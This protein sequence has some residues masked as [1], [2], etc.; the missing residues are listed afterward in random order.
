MSKSDGFGKGFASDIG[1]YGAGNMKHHRHMGNFIRAMRLDR[2]W[3]MQTLADMCVPPTTSSQI[4]K[5]E[6]GQVQ[7]TERWMRI[8][9]QALDC[10]AFDLIDGGPE[11]LAPR[12]QSLVDLFR[13]L[14]EA[15]RD[16]FY[17]TAA[18]LAEP[19][20]DTDDEGAKTKAKTR[21]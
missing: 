4:N 6:K 13:G 8:L 11:R 15:Q 3:S 18:A 10:Q 1:V 5:L 21:P 2:G 9:S 12:E 16:A 14:S 7:L 20:T 17:R 19:H